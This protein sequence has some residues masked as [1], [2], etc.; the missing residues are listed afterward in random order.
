[1]VH[2]TDLLD[3]IPQSHVVSAEDKAR[4]LAGVMKH[5]GARAEWHVHRLF[6]FGGSE[7]GALI[8]HMQDLGGGGFTTAERIVQQKLLK[9]LPEFET[10]HMRRGNVL[11]PLAR[12]AFMYR[13]GAVQDHDA[14]ARMARPHGRSDVP[15]LVGNPDDLVMVKGRRLLPD[16]KVP[17]TYSEHVEFDYSAQLHHYALGARLRGI[18]IDGLVLAKLDLSPATAEDL[19]QKL[20]GASLEEIERV[21]RLIAEAD[22]PGFRVVAQVIEQSKSMYVDILATGKL[23]WEDFVLQGVIP[24]QVVKPPLPVSEE[25]LSAIGALETQYAKL[26]AAK[27]MLER[28]QKNVAALLTAAIS[29]IDAENFS[30]PHGLVIPKVAEAVKEDELIAA[31]MECG[32]EESDLTEAAGYSE[33]ALLDE[34]KRLGG[35]IDNPALLATKLSAAKAEDFLRSNDIPTEEFKTRTQGIRLS[36]RSDAK[37]MTEQ[38]AQEASDMLDGW[39]GGTADADLADDNFL[40]EG[41]ARSSRTT[42]KPR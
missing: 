7:M 26:G 3:R 17:N 29:G 32:A 6:G 5:H 40:E 35:D 41:P 21:G 2:L 34:I 9:R 16:Y 38:F 18:Q 33:Q 4:W 1:M 28:E 31:A 25:Q 8:R 42:M 36:T 27:G 24:K 13:Y 11:E 39:V 12:A 20:E 15:W 10:N 14:I 30:T 22:L 37:R 19:V 23:Y